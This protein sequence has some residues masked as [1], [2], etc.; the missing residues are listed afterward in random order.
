VVSLREDTVARHQNPT[1]DG[2]SARFGARFEKVYRTLLRQHRWH[3][4]ELADSLALEEAELRPM[5]RQLHAEGL[6][7]G[8]ADEAGAVRAVE[9]AL[10]LA[11]L[12]SRRVDRRTGNRAAAAPSPDPVTERFAPLDQWFA[13]RSGE[14]TCLDGMDEVTT[15]VERLIMRARH[16]T[17]LLTPRYLPG[18]FEFRSQIG[19]TVLRRGAELKTVWGSAVLDSPEAVRYARSRDSRWPAPRAASGVDVR[20]VIIDRS[21]AVVLGK[22]GYAQILCG[23]PAFEALLA[24]ADYLWEHSIALRSVAEIR[25]STPRPRHELVLELLAEGLTDQAIARRIGVSIRTVRND[26]ALVMGSLGARSRFQAGVRAVCLGLL[27]S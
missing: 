17:I 14:W 18:S 5:I 1:T 23:G 15:L 16:E 6:V 11:S 7:V 19:E 9:P 25:T 27:L 13:E 8:S 26:V 21:L 4:G 20:A 10:A 24:S 22:P 3:V 2:V 12:A